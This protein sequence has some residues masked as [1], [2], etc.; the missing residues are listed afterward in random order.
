MG[1]SWMPLLVAVC[2]GCT[3][4]PVAGPGSVSGVDGAAG[5]DGA[6]QLA[7]G[8]QAQVDALP[9]DD[10]W[11]W[12]ADVGQWQKDDASSLSD[13]A[14]LDDSWG[15][16][17]SGDGVQAKDGSAAD[18]AKADLP[19]PAPGEPGAPCVAHSDCDSGI[20]AGVGSADAYCT[21]TGCSAQSDCVF[22]S[23]W[24]VCC[25]TYAKKSFCLKQVGATSCGVQDKLPGESCV[26]GG[27]SDCSGLGNWCFQQ[28]DEAQ[29]VQGCQ[30]SNSPCPA[31]TACQVFAGGGGCLPFTAGVPDG[32]PCA[33]KAIGGCDK[34]AYCIGA[35][36]DDPFAY[37]ATGCKSDGECKT[38]FACTSFGGDLGVCIQYGDRG[39]GQNCA[40][41]RFS[42][43]KGLWCVGSENADAICTPQCTVDANC[44]GLG[45]ALGGAA[46]CAKGAGSAVG[47]CYPKGSEQN[48]A[49]CAK[50][51][52][53]CAQGEFCIG[54]Y[55]VYNPDAICQTS[56]GD[57]TSGVC[58]ANSTCIA[59]NADYS[60]CQVN[61]TKGQGESCAGAPTACKAGFF[62][63]G[64][65]G[66]EVCV[67]Q[68]K[69]GPKDCPGSGA[70]PATTWCAPYGDGKQG[71][72]LGAGDVAVGQPCGS[73]PWSCVPGAFCEGF[74]S[75]K[76]AVCIASCAKDGSCP[77]NTDCKDFG[78]AGKYCEPTGKK[79]QGQSC[80][81]DA[82]SCAPGH[83]CIAKGT[84]QAMCSKQCNGD[85]D[86]ATGNWCGLGKWGGYCLPTGSIPKNGMCYQNPWGC[87]KGLLCLGDP[88]TNPGSFCAAEC[89]G[90]ASA[91][92]ADEKC[93]YLGGGQA[94]CIKT[95]K[96]P[97]GSLCF[98]NPLGCDPSTL[99]IKGTP[100]PTCLTTCGVGKPECPADS[101]CTYFVGSALKLCVPKGFTPF[102][103]IR[104]PF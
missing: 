86:C 83:V 24:P 102:G 34:G 21:T 78:Q 96:M 6:A 28:G 39:A 42:C 41:N 7:D 93:E 58:P 67:Q 18:G 36:K 37:C 97:A 94:W 85:S 72:C 23:E 68:C 74:G 26:S 71:V 44:D 14:S 50:N 61:G 16:T 12:N 62:C 91:C 80:I 87:A 77:N 75:A 4:A 55:D 84:P 51:P 81:D 64:A 52:Y 43:K 19:P 69:F 95:G 29:C 103:A 66:K 33:A 98:E 27:Q 9:P 40:D 70:S 11:V 20:C 1:R 13:A 48:G 47:V 65:Q 57:A 104:V 35:A 79:T 5:G 101:P 59:Y 56:C 15:D 76:D 31:G 82:N 54:G 25:V 3:D 22:A 73:K 88:A 2:V 92:A 60:G 49:S 100:Q 63:L 46:Y 17:A 99:C 30:A 10:A 32:S 38:G 45:A 90:F 89:S 53:V 8:W